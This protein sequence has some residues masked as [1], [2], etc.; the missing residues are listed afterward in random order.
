MYHRVAILAAGKD[1]LLNTRVLDLACG[2]GGG[3]GFLADH[4]DLQIGVGIDNCTRQISF[5]MDTFKKPS[6]PS[7]ALN[8]YV[9][10]IENAA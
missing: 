5:A 8:F 3:L 1:N 7:S 4:F 10:D 9:G 2:R 6:L